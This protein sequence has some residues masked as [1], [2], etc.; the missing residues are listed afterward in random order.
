M[1]NYFKTG[2]IFS[3]GLLG[4]TQIMQQSP[5][6]KRLAFNY[7]S[8]LGLLF[9][10]IGISII[11]DDR[12]D[13]SADQNVIDKEMEKDI[14]Q[15][16]YTLKTGFYLESL[17]NDEQYDDIELFVELFENKKKT[18]EDVEKISRILNKR[19]VVKEQYSLGCEGRHLYSG[20]SEKSYP[21]VFEN[22]RNIRVLT[23]F[24]FCFP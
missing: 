9:Q 14:Y 23:F 3:N 24:G 19:T 20:S 4:V 5:Q 21:V 6:M 16:I 1:K 12:L 11:E 18:A 2:T 8:F 7:G 13:I 22:G 15:S 17:K 10:L